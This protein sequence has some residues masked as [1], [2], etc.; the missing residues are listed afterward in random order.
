MSQGSAGESIRIERAAVQQTYA[1][2]KLRQ[3]RDPARPLSGERRH[4]LLLQVLE[5][6]FI[7]RYHLEC[8]RQEATAY[9]GLI[10]SLEA[11]LKR[12]ETSIASTERA[13]HSSEQS[14]E[15]S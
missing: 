8:A 1:L 15:N 3:A 13:L 2:R 11:Y 9:P 7:A 4:Q 14:A 6:L 10:A 5:H 12:L